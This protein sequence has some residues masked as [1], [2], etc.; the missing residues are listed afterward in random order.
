MTQ[1][2]AGRVRGPHRR[3][4]SA[5]PRRGARLHQ[6][7]RGAG[8]ETTTKLIGHTVRTLA[9]RPDQRRELR[10]EHRPDPQRHRGDCC[11]SRRRRPIQARYVAEDVEFHG[12]TVPA[13][14]AILL[15]N[16]AAN[17]DDRKWGD[18]AEEYDI[19]RKIDHHLSFGYGLHFCLGAALARLEGRVAL[20]EILKRFPDWSIDYDRSERSHTST[21]RGWDKLTVVLTTRR[22]PHLAITPPVHVTSHSRSSTMSLFDLFRYDGKRVVVVGAATGMGNAA[23]RLLVDAGAEV[24]A[25][26]FAPMDIDGIAGAITVNLADKASIDAAVDECGGRVDALFSCAGVADGTPGI[27]KINFLGHRHMINQM[28]DAGDARS[29]QRH[30]VH[31][32][33]RRCR[34]GARRQHGVAR[35]VPGHR[36]HGRGVAVGDRQRQ[37]RLLPEQARGLLV[38]G[39]QA[40]LAA[41][42]GRADQRDHARARPTRPSPRRTRRCGSASVPTTA[43][44]P[45]SRRRRRRTRRTRSCSCAATPPKRSP[46]SR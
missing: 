27:E 29:R 26:D 40:S 22:P 11:A 12:Q 44:T 18:T 34:L 28:L 32:L 41:E 38:R 21:V 15:V 16:G 19:H 45:V 42:E 10:A 31:L 25:M 3:H 33:G 7:A 8:N 5:D 13:G 4:A 1:L 6:P 30:R 17:H 43:R 35:R 20:D 37:G 46:G 36:R 39:P 14:S 23:A 9:E 24:V 2:R